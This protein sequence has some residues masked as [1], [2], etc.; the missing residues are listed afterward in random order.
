MSCKLAYEYFKIFWDMGKVD[1]FKTYFITI[2]S[3]KNVAFLQFFYPRN[4]ALIMYT[5]YHDYMNTLVY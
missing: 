1:L 4:L 3:K 5:V 2:R